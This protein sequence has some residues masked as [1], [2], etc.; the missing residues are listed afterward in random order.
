[1]HRGRTRALGALLAMCVLAVIGVAPRAGRALV[2]SKPIV[3]PNAI[4]SLASHEWERL[5]ATVALAK[6]WPASLVVLT[7]PEAVTAFNC[8]D[9]ANRT[10]RLALAGVPA[11]RV[12]VV[13]L[14]EGGTYG[15]AL[16]VRRLAASDR[17]QRVLVVTSPYHTRRALATFEAV[18]SSTGVQVGVEPAS[19]TSPAE[20]ARWWREPY[21]RAYVRYEWAALLYYRVRY[22]VSL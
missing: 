6:R 11:S 8:H 20:P 10:H 3:A 13:Q 5:P 9:C 17:L 14:R 19:S 18:L 4:V 2:V 15:E 22:G 16:A 1:M 21:D 12:R 7:L